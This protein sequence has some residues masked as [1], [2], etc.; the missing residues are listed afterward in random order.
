VVGIMF[1]GADP[2]ATGFQFGDELYQ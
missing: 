1:D 2:V